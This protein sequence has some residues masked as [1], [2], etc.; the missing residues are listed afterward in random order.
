[1]TDGSF[2]GGTSP[3]HCLTTFGQCT[4]YAFMAPWLAWQAAAAS[5]M[6]MLTVHHRV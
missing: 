2:V 4:E 1:M 3:A 5:H 6:F